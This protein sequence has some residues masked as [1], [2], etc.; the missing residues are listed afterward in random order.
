MH[1]LLA[2]MRESEVR[3]VA[4]EVSAQALSCNRVDGL[5]F[6]VVA[7]TNLSH[8]HL[9]DY[10]DMEEYFQ[11]KL[12]LLQ[13]DRGQARRRLPRLRRGAQRVVEESRIPVTTIVVGT[14]PGRRAPS[15]SSRSSTSR[16]R[17]PSSG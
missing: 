11:A 1:A 14:H 2:R 9:D 16:P 10:A 12:A 17:T 8:D 7:F 3:A 13:P 6:D 4:I 5:V 15:G